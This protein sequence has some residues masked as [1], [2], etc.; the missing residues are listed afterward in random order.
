M[1]KLK[2]LKDLDKGDFIEPIIYPNE[3]KQEVIKWIKELKSKEYNTQDRVENKEWYNNYSF[4]HI[5]SDEY[6][7]YG[8]TENVVNWIKHFFNITDEDL[9]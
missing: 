5:Y 6:G 9:E 7:S 4:S 8:V 1:N 2:I 3:L